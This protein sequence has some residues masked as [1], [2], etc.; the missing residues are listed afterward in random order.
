VLAE[1]TEARFLRN[2]NKNGPVSR[3]TN[4]PCWLWTGSGNKGNYG[5]VLI[6]KS[7]PIRFVSAHRYSWTYYYG[8][9][10]HGSHVLHKCDNRRCV[11]PEHLKLGTAAQNSKDIVEHG[12]S[13]RGE[14]NPRTKLTTNDVLEIRAKYS[15]GETLR[16]IAAQYS[17]SLTNAH[18]ITT[19]RSW[20]H[21]EEV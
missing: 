9:I 10:P 8:E 5:R 15:R 11:N 1:S 4:T 14:L 21:L 17:I 3:F 19:R 20:A 6:S 13:L 2:I 7:N 18:S 16:A 12:N